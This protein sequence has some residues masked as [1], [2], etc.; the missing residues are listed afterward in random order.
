MCVCVCVCVCV[1]DERLNKALA[2]RTQLFGTV[3]VS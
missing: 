1:Y 3:F 2:H